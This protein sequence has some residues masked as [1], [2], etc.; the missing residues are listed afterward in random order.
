MTGQFQIRKLVMTAVLL[1]SL[2]QAFSDEPA[3]AWGND[4]HGSQIIVIPFDGQ[5]VGPQNR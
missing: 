1:A 5:G 3:G 4:G 2:G